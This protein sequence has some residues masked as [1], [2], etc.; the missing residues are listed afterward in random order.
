[1]TKELLK[2]YRYLGEI[3][4]KDEEKLRYYKE[5][6]PAAY[7]GKVQSSNKEFPYQRTSVEV[8]G[9]E[10]KDRRAWK[11]KQYELIE[12]L[13]H[14]RAKL[15]QM[16]LEIDIFFTTIYDSRDRLIFEYLYQD[17]MT[18]QEV[19]EK[20]FMERSTVSRVVD[21]Y[22]ACQSNMGS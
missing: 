8:P 18:Q 19:A 17:G 12:K 20:L 15:E 1:M 14:E 5:N 10:I 13:Y 6:P 7:V 11:Q 21:R 9:C 22:L 2:Q 16:K 4:R 3:I